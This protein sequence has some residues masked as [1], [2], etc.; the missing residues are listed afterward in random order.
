MSAIHLIDELNRRVMFLLHQTCLQLLTIDGLIYFAVTLIDQVI[1]RATIARAILHDL[2]VL[3]RD[4]VVHLTTLLDRVLAL[5]VIRVDAFVE[6]VENRP[7]LC[8]SSD[9]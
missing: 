7:A 1:L 2:P 8:A 6:L 9:Y 3:L 5:R 4:H